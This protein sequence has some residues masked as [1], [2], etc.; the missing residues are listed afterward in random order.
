MQTSQWKEKQW[1]SLWMLINFWW[2]YWTLWQKVTVKSVCSLCRQLD[3]G[4]IQSKG[5]RS[6][7]SYYSYVHVW[8]GFTL[9]SHFSSNLNNVL[10]LCSLMDVSHSG[11][12]KQANQWFVGRIKNGDVIFLCHSQTNRGGEIAINKA[13]NVNELDTS[14]LTDVTTP[15]GIHFWKCKYRVV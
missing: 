12:N 9:L 8:P 1:V 7:T 3:W 15:Q 11:R 6:I 4:C 10:V 13:T 2:W 5:I 14:W